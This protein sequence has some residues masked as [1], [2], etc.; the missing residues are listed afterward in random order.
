MKKIV[1]A[2]ISVYF[3]YTISANAMPYQPRPSAIPPGSYTQTCS[4]CLVDAS[5]T[6][7]CTCADHSGIPRNTSLPNARFCKSIENINGQ[8]T[9]AQKQQQRPYKHPRRPNRGIADIQ[10]GPIWNQSHAEQVCYSTCQ[11][12]RG[13]WTGQWRTTVPA[14]MSVCQCKLY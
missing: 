6:L 14:Q 9:C 7:L 10:V 4:S 5:N 13:T 12:N 2:L 11:N 8:L 1:L 3:I